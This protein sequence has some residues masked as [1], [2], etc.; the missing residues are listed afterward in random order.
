MRSA[1]FWQVWVGERQRVD[2]RGVG[3]GLTDFGRVVPVELELN[4]AHAR[5]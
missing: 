1:K 2:S 3:L 5:F 4:F